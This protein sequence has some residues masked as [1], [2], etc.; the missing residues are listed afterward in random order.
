MASATVKFEQVKLSY[1]Y[2]EKGENDVNQL[3]TVEVKRVAEEANIS[4]FKDKGN[5]LFYGQ[6]DRTVHEQQTGYFL[7][8]C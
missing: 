5:C 2:K 6:D 1:L 7:L 8:N 3:F 4:I